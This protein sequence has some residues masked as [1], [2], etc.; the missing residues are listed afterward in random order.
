[1]RKRERT[2]KAAD[3]GKRKGI[4]AVPVVLAIAALLMLGGCMKEDSAP[5]MTEPDVIPSV[6][7]IKTV[8]VIPDPSL[9]ALIQSDPYAQLASYAREAYR[10]DRELY[11]FL[12]SAVEKMETEVDLSGFPLTDMEK[13]RTMDALYAAAAFELY[14]MYRV[15]LSPDAMKVRVRYRDTGEDVEAG[16]RIFF[17][18][19]SHLIHNV[20]LDSYS[21]LQKLFA[22][23]DQVTALADYT[24]DISNDA[25]HIPYSI[26]MEGKGICGGFASLSYDLLNRAGVETAYV[27]N[28][29]HA[30]NLVRID[31]QWYHSDMTWGA[32]SYGSPVNAINTILMDEDQRDRS[33]ENSGYGGFPIIE[34]YPRD[35][36]TPPVSATD[37][38]FRSF[39]DFYYEYVLDIDS[40][41]VYFAGEEGIMRMTLSGDEVETLSPLIATG[42]RMFDGTLYFIGAEDGFLY[43]LQ[44]G[45]GPDLLDDS[46]MAGSL[47]IDK[48]ILRY[49][50]DGEGK[51]LDLNP[52]DSSSFNLELSIHEESVT[53]PLEQT[54]RMEITFST[55]MDQAVL[56]KDT[57]GLMNQDG[58]PLPIHMAWNEDGSVLTVRAREY[59]DGEDKVMLLVSPG[60]LAADGGKTEDAHDLSVEIR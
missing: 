51:S 30:W 24:D 13:W 27:S 6:P 58:Q 25:S 52:F 1:M 28:E 20:A 5:G 7:V 17:S 41:F 43:R 48:G 29:P 19:R 18:R 12:Y 56:P 36:A 33:L 39:Y 4:R 21:D 59:L 60:T 53:V 42:L 37:D 26:L 49:G 10:P 38:R 32:G 16:R 57:V 22:V 40:G 34:G 47:S 23:Y 2:G 46:V 3:A 15:N 54:F 11:N 45:K 55:A 44:R 35:G 50:G 8:A 31:G 9:E 14:P